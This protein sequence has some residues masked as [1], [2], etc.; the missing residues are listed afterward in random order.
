MGWALSKLLAAASC[1]ALAACSQPLRGD[2]SPSADGQTYLS[3]ESLDGSACTDLR[4]D[5]K[6]WPFALGTPGPIA[7]G[8][9]E[10]QCMSPIRFT[11]RSGTV[12]RFRYWGP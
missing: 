12:F 2:E 8:E 1:C 10:I 9:H 4:V 7:P 11:V 5:G 3:V 6:P